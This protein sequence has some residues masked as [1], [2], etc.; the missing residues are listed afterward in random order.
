MTKYGERM[1]DLYRSGT[2]KKDIIS[3][4]GLLDL[5]PLQG[6]SVFITGAGGL[7]CST[8][9]DI[10]IQANEQFDKKIKVYA[11]GRDI[12]RLQKRFSGYRNRPELFFVEYDACSG[13]KLDFS[14][15]FI[16]HGASN[17]SPESFVS[18]PVE[19]LLSNFNGMDQLLHYAC[20]NDVKRVL[21]ISS[22]EVYGTGQRSGAI[23]ESECGCVDINNVRSSYAVGKQ[24]S[25]MLCMSYIKEYG[26]DCVVVRPGHVFGPTASEKDKRVSSDFAYRAFYGKDLVLK[27]SGEQTRSYCYCPDCAS[28]IIEVLL[29]GVSG[30]AYNI[31]DQGSVM[32]IRELSEL[33]AEYGNVRLTY[34]DGTPSEKAA[35]NPMKNS[36]LDGNKLCALGWKGLFDGRTGIEH[37]V[38]ILR[39]AYCNADD[40]G[41]K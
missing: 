32:T 28:A 21:Y 36:A 41:A 26:V 37:T 7:I 25:E 16:I 5:K 13:L 27:S 3:E 14:V 35:F 1:F 9:V 31:S 29:N 34:E 20:S 30:Q 18:K 10:F 12:G 38:R 40:G 39:E 23:K 8:L 22:S 17:A 19:T 4:V 2:Y 11:A 15:D 6:K 24:S 33:F